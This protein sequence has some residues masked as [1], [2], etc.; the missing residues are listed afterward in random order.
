MIGTAI[1]SLVMA[2]IATAVGGATTYYAKKSEANALK[3]QA[4]A[5]E[6]QTEAEAREKERQARFEDVRAGVAQIRGEQEAEKRSRVLAQDI[7]R[8]YAEYAGNGLLVDGSG[9]DSVGAA[10]RTQATEAQADIGTIR[11]NTAMEVWT[12]LANAGSYRASAGNTRIAGAN[13]AA[14]IRYQAKQARH[15]GKL[16]LWQL[17]TGLPLV[18]SGGWSQASST[19]GGMGGLRSTPGAA[20]PSAS[21]NFAGTQGSG[22]AASRYASYA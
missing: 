10:L 1:A 11:D 2:G 16:G 20:Q 13:R 14:A 7:G 8:M 6:Q 12:H 17:A 4:L 3:K 21:P 15:V 18:S 19:V 9:K 5:E 22:G